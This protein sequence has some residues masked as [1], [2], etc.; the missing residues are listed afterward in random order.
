MER[1]WGR[2]AGAGG[3][4]VCMWVASFIMLVHPTINPLFVRSFDSTS[5]RVGR[6]AQLLGAD[7]DSRH[8]CVHGASYKCCD[9]RQHCCACGESCHHSCHC[10]TLYLTHRRARTKRLTRPLGTDAWGPG[11]YYLQMAGIMALLWLVS[12]LK[13]WSLHSTSADEDNRVQRNDATGP[14]F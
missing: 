10:L 2:A 11:G 14:L 4:N 6:A 12:L 5:I 3:S 8:H 9:R 1:L 7:D 13:H